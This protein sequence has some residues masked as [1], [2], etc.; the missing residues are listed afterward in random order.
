MN[1][2]FKQIFIIDEYIILK[3]SNKT[4]SKFLNLFLFNKLKLQLKKSEQTWNSV[5]KMSKKIDSIR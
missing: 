1:S 4:I 3:I 2:F 5:F